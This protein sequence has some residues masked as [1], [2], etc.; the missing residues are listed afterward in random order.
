MIYSL[1]DIL[2]SDAHNI[3]YDCGSHSNDSRIDVDADGIPRCSECDAQYAEVA[4]HAS[5][6]TE[7]EATFTDEHYNAGFSCKSC[8][9]ELQRAIRHIIHRGVPYAE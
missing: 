6:C 5:N 4:V 3:C 2:L 7:C 8:G 9:S 1:N